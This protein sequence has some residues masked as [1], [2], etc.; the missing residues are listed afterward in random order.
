[1]TTHTP[2]QN[3][4][5]NRPEPQDED[6]QRKQTVLAVAVIVA[7]SVIVVTWIM[8]LPFQLQKMSVVSEEEMARWREVR[9]SVQQDEITLQQALSGLRDSY[10]S[11][12]DRYRESSGVDYGTGRVPAEVIDRLKNKIREL[13]NGEAE[14]DVGTVSEEE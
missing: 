11:L 14:F 9:D 1:M 2:S 13:E 10:D 5:N 7:T 12:E 6:R 8:L 4:I 3:D